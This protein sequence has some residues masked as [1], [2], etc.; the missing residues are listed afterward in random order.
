MANS[1]QQHLPS[2]T[3]SPSPRVL[4]SITPHLFLLLLLASSPSPLS[5]YLCCS[6]HLLPVFIITAK[7]FLYE[8]EREELLSV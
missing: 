3:V 2:H 7:G 6:I 8:A 1:W 5:H 4:Q